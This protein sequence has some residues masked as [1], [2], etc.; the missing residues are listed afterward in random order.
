MIL[1]NRKTQERVKASIVNFEYE[2]FAKVKKNKGFDFNWKKERDFQLYKLK[3]DQTDEILGVMSIIDH[4]EELRIE[5]HLLEVAKSHRGKK[6]VIEGIAGSLIAFACNIAFDKAY[7][8]FVSLVPKTKLINHYINEYGF[9]QFG[10][11]LAL[12]IEE[13]RELV[14]KYL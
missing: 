7:F 12:D 5:I 1:Y 6:K 9:K 13:A 3:I 4:P 11:Q 2:D 10:R 8:G 14:A